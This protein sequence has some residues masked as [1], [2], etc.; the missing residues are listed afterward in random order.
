[1]M[2]K[3]DVEM[4]DGRCSKSFVQI[5]EGTKQVMYVPTPIIARNLKVLADRKSVV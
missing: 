1:M 3:C 4:A 2:L 5:D